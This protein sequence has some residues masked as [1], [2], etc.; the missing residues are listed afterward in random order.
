MNGCLDLEE[1]LAKLQA[2]IRSCRRCELALS[3]RN[4]VLGEGPHHAKIMIVG[5]APGEQEDLLGKP[6]VGAAGHFLNNLLESVNLARKH[7]F[8]T[9]VVKCRPPSNRPPR[10][11]EIAACNPYLLKQITLIRPR[12]I[13]PMGNFAIKTLTHKSMP[14]SKVHGIP[15][16]KDEVLFFP[17][18][19]PAA[20]LYD[21]KLK[22]VLFQDFAKL[23]HLL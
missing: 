18:Y 19:H 12:I 20:A 6:F 11:R 9:N 15:E 2:K 16:K 13:C 7:V 1:D 8:I 14:V 17:T 4:A 3:R 22:E 5:E 10:K 21:V 23:K